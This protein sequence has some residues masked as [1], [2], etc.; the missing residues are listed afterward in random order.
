MDTIKCL[1]PHL[2]LL[3]NIVGAGILYMPLGL[4]LFV[5]LLQMHPLLPIL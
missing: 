2:S 3:V 5:K 1:T 4:S